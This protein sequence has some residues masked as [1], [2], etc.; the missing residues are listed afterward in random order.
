[1]DK[2]L[3]LI[4]FVFLAQDVFSQD[5]EKQDT[6]QEVVVTGNMRT[7]FKS[8]SIVP[9]E[10]YKP[11]FFSK[12]PTM[13]FF[14]SVELINGV[15]PQINCNVCN[16]GDIHINGMEGPYTLILIDGMPIVSGLSTVYGLS[17]IPNSLVERVELVKGPAA[18]LYG[19]EA[20]GGIINIIT[21]SPNNSPRLSV[22]VMGTGWG[23]SQ[24]DVSTAFKAGKWNSLL[25]IN[26][27]NFQQRIDRNNDGF[28]DMALQKRIALFNK[29]TLERK[30]GKELSIAGRY[31]WEERWGGQ[32]NWGKQFLGTDS[33]YGEYIETNRWE[34]L[35]QYQL[36]TKEDIRVQWSLNGHRQ[37]SMYGNTSFD[38][39]QTVAFVQAL[40]NKQWREHQRLLVG[41]TYRYTYYDDNTPATEGYVAAKHTRL[42]GVFVQNESEWG[43]HALLLGYRLDHHSAHGWVSSP[44]VGWKYNINPV[45]QI[46]LSAGTGYR[47]VSIFTEDH[48]ALSGAREVVIKEALKPEQSY[49]F[50][51]QYSNKYYLNSWMID[52]DINVFYNYFTNKIIADLDT[53]PQLIIYDNLE[54]YAVNRGLGL[55]ITA[56]QS[57]RWQLQAGITYM[58]VYSKEG[59]EKTIQLYAPR[60]TGNLIVSRTLPRS[61]TVDFTN[62]WNGPMRLP[63]VPNDFRPEYSPWYILSNLQ[64]KKA[65]KSFEVYGGI[66]N[67]FD[68]VP[69]NGILRPF[70]PFDK[71]SDED[72][73]G[74]TFDPSY[75]YASLQGRRGFLGVRYTF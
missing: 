21:K 50:L 3:L 19:S 33:V 51:A 5:K 66:K 58:D 11:A 36:A 45:Q 24:A 74:Y 41:A 9:I 42:P 53:D 22:D 35:G 39:D 12:N 64:L 16:T 44:R 28:T 68:F 48:A 62:K 43:K 27:Y 31:V 71:Y 46:R 20:M 59:G 25:G 38:A 72:P 63:V 23:E 47:V 2:I 32:T 4:G 18:A 56:I 15:Q 55:N 30:S 26:H 52:A 70:D 1:M 37:R 69:K 7:V 14:E 75:N 57:N 65:W 29:W 60:Y 10:L 49:N 8:A 61:W 54:G 17:G 67:I 34:V 40:W 13:S 73:N 6:L